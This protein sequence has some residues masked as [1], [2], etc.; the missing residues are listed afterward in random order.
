MLVSGCYFPVLGLQ[1]ALGRLLDPGR[2]SQHRRPLRRRAQ[3][4][5]LDD[6]ARRESRSAQRDDHRQR[7]GADDRRRR[8]A[9]LR[10]HDAR[11]RAEG[12]RADHDARA[13]VARLEGLR[14][15]PEL[16]GLPVRAAEAGRVDRAGARGDQRRLPR[17]HQRR[18]SAAAER[19]ERSD[20]GAVQGESRS[21]SSRGQRGQS[22]CTAKPKPPLL[23]LL[24]SPAS[25]C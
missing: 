14:Q 16:L 1:P 10:R 24:A 20:A 5:L 4:R 22:S 3:P 9:R 21:A 12:L 15:P 2:R 25:C 18:R 6:A 11:Q 13:D 7:P 8:A 23:L 17:H 19:H